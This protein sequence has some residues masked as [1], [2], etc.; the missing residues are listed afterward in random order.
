M[1]YDKELDICKKNNTLI[2][3]DVY[4]KIL[5]IKYL[6]ESLYTN[7]VLPSDW[8][9][10]ITDIFEE[11]NNKQISRNYLY[12]RQR[13]DIEIIKKICSLYLSSRS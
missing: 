12:N 11:L 9:Q 4:N 13:F 10:Q 6:G 3:Y 8:K 1:I 5:Y 2:S 7:F